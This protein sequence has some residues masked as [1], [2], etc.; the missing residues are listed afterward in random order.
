MT[1]NS[2]WLLCLDEAVCALKLSHILGCIS[3][4][5]EAALHAGRAARIEV[6]SSVGLGVGA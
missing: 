6:G 5:G 4:G 3:A 2:G 1:P